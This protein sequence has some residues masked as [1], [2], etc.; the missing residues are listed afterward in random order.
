MSLYHIK[1]NEEVSTYLL[2]DFTTFI[3]YIKENDFL[4][5]IDEGNS[6][7]TCVALTKFGLV[8]FSHYFIRI[9]AICN[10]LE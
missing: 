10:S 9:G 4:I 5:M 6:K 8:Q 1:Q 2:N 7:R 3:D